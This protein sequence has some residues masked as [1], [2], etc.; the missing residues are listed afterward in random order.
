M[1]TVQRRALIDIKEDNPE[2]HILTRVTAVL[3]TNSDPPSS[4][5]FWDCEGTGDI[6]RGKTIT[7]ERRWWYMSPDD[8]NGSVSFGITA[9]ESN[10][11]I[12]FEIDVSGA[13]Q[14]KKINMLDKFPFF[15]NMKGK[16]IITAVGGR[17]AN[18]TRID[19]KVVQ[20]T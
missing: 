2:F 5:T 17:F 12:Q 6:G 7:E 20:V 8:Q 11:A 13:L 3:S 18:G 14:E 19:Y 16:G 9:D 1:G 15:V 10:M 4:V